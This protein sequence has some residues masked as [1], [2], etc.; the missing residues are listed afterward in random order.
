MTKTLTA[1]NVKL[2]RA[3][4]HAV[5]EDGTRI[6]IDRLWPREVEKADAAIDQWVKDI[7][8]STALRKWFGHQPARW[9]EFRRRYAVEVRAHPKQLEGLR[10]MARQGPITLAYSAHDEVHN[11]A[12]A[13]TG[14][15]LRSQTTRRRTLV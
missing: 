7:A 13:L 12:V 5:A 10:A 1:G 4:E 8:P 6:L 11:D 9:Q 15:L 14:F 2:K 3:Y